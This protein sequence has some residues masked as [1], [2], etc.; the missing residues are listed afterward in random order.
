[1][2]H[3]LKEPEFILPEVLERTI[4]LIFLYIF[5]FTKLFPFASPPYFLGWE[6]GGCHNMKKL[7]SSLPEGTSIQVEAFLT[8]RFLKE[9]FKIFNLYITI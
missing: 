2:G 5:L 3:D 4:L 1:M 9:D 6:G 7:E 8:G